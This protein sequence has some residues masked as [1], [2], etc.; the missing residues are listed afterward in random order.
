MRN[1]RNPIGLIKN[2]FSMNSYV[3]LSNN[4]KYPDN[5]NSCFIT[6]LSQ[7]FLLNENSSVALVEI[8]YFNDL[9]INLGKLIVEFERSNTNLHYQKEIDLIL[10]DFKDVLTSIQKQYDALIS[11][12]H[13]FNHYM[14][15]TVDGEDDMLQSCQAD[16]INDIK[17][18]IKCLNDIKDI[19][20]DCTFHLEFNFIEVSSLIDSFKQKVQEQ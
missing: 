3:N 17:N 15:R 11:S 1:K 10:S 14:D 20:I 13:F 16:I 5:S 7:P 19:L 18:L 6:Q 9:S 4:D 12:I 2:N 8:N